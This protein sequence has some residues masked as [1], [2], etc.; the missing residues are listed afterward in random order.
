MHDRP[1][2]RPFYVY[3]KIRDT[4]YAFHDKFRDSAAN[5]C[6]LSLN[7]SRLILGTQCRAISDLYFPRLTYIGQ[8][9]IQ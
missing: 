9:N 1:G 6:L 5:Q 3:V 7:F 4:L 2:R 8:I